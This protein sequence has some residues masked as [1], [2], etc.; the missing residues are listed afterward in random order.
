MIG[1][2]CNVVPLTQRHVTAAVAFL[3]ACYGD[4]YYGAD[5]TYF[6]WLYLESP[7]AWFE[8]ERER[9]RIPVNGVFDA[10]GGLEAIHAYLPFDAVTPWGGSI[11]VWDVEW[12]NASG[13]GGTG[14]ALASRLLEQVDVYAGYG[15]NQRSA[16][17][18]R[19]MGLTVVDEI[20]RLV[21]ILDRD[22]L[23][24]LCAQNGYPFEASALPP[25]TVFCEGPWHLLDRAALVPGAILAAARRGVRFGV[26]RSPAWLG[27]RYDRHPFIAYRVVAP[28]PM[29]ERGA[30]VVRVER[31]VGSDLHVCRVLDFFFAPGHESA[32]LAAVLTYAREQTCLV[33]DY[34]DTA[35]TSA[36]LVE[37][38]ARSLDASLLWT[39]RVPFMFQP[40][41]FNDRNSINLVI[42]LGGRARGSTE[43]GAFHATKADSNQD[44]LRDSR[45]S[46]RPYP[47]SRP[48]F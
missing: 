22:R 15:C 8:S 2:R 38:A 47:R 26:S 9:D 32:L 36:H 12:I 4:D 17:A 3:R 11:G 27:W 46:P 16:S 7:C 48:D 31:I 23:G 34:F 33:A 40:T 41:A 21:A 10:K 19:K 43:L 1:E 18:F 5:E 37:T 13:V 45:T 14:Q 29:G 44:V 6:R 35:A 24:D 25:V 30:A 39:P 28:D 42:A 20:P